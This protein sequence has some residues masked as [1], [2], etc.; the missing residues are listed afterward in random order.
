MKC[1]SL[2]MLVRGRSAQCDEEV[3]RGLLAGESVTIRQESDIVATLENSQSLEGLVFMPE[4]RKFCGG[5]F[6]VLRPVNKLIV[7]GRNGLRELRSAVILEGVTCDGEAHRGCQYGCMLLWKE[8]WLTLEA[9]SE[10]RPGYTSTDSSNRENGSA[11]SG[12]GLVCQTSRLIEATRPLHFYDWRQYAWD[13]QTG[14]F[15]FGVLLRTR[16][17]LAYNA[18]R[19]RLGLR[20]Y[21]L[22]HGEAR[23]TPTE[24]LNLRP[25]ELVEVKS[26]RDIAAMLDARGR[27]R[28]LSFTQEMLRCCGRRYHVLRRLDRMVVEATGSMREFSDTVLLDTANCD[29]EAHFNC[30]RGCN[31]LFKEIWLKRV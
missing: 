22:F 7:E 13:I 19:V 30:Q 2:E 15:H 6:K 16:L 31:F 9:R 23:S 26:R 20:K 21:Y 18:L 28:G 27:T 3:K 14:R 11:S 1:Q 5:T 17:V 8:D 24:T 4:M 25:G 10:S 29:G 12:G